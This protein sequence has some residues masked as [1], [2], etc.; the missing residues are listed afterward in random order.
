MTGTSASIFHSQIINDSNNHSIHVY[1]L[2]RN[3]HT[4]LGEDLNLKIN[5]HDHTIWNCVMG[6]SASIFHSHPPS[7]EHFSLKIDVRDQ[8]IWN[9]ILEL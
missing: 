9:C 3:P 5:G 1:Y 4:L 6:S 8:T 2:S 7:R